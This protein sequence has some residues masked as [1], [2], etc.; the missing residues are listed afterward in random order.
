VSLFPS[1]C[2]AMILASPE[3]DSLPSVWIWRCH[4]I[5]LSAIHGNGYRPIAQPAPVQFSAF[6]HPHFWCTCRTVI[7]MYRAIV[8][9]DHPLVCRSALISCLTSVVTI[10]PLR[11]VAIRELK[12]EWHS[13]YPANTRCPSPCTAARLRECAHDNWRRECTNHIL[14]YRVAVSAGSVLVSSPKHEAPRWRLPMPYL[15][16]WPVVASQRSVAAV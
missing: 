7:P 11:A 15:P 4:A 8:R 3:F 12:D 2:I 13:R 16:P 5:P 14:S 9:T 10:V 6:G 1:T